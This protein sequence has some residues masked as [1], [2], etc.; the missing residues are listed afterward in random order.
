MDAGHGAAHAAHAEDRR[1][2][3]E[4]EPARSHL[5]LTG[6][7]VA[8]PSL[9]HND[10]VVDT[11]NRKF[12]IADEGIGPG[13]DGTKAALVVV[14][15]DT[16][17]VRR[18]LQGHVSTLPEDRPITVDGK[19]LTVPGKDGK[20]VVIK[21]GADGIAADKNFEW[22]YYGPLNGTSIYRVRIADLNNE[23]LSD[24]ELGARVERYAA[25]PNNGG[26]SIDA[27]GNLYLTEVETKAVGIIS[28]NDTPISP[29]CLERSADL[30]RWRQLRAGWVHVCF[31]GANLT[32][33]ALQWRTA[34]KQ[35]ALPHFPIQAACCGSRWSL[36]YAVLRR[37]R[38][39]APRDAC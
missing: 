5:L 22:L 15:M 13:G 28:A 16:G 9:Q 39:S 19:V 29:L 17:A 23:T 33:G 20:P 27:D 26:L 37:T 3:Y 18:L 31:R 34:P 32:R 4:S 12:Y 6:A 35:A 7:R 21:V 11:K 1:M 25:K 2:E 14:D 10:F 36:S 8:C 30:A 24:A 38:A